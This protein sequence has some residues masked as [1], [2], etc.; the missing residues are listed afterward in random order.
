[1]QINREIIAI[2]LDKLIDTIF[3]L[4]EVTAVKVRDVIMKK[5]EERRKKR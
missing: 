3:Q 5:G 1:M 4:P 2:E